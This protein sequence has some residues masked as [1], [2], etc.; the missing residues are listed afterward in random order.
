MNLNKYFAY[1][2][3]KGFSDIEFKTRKNSKLS[4]TVYHS[5]VEQY[6][7]SENETLFIRG[8][9]NGKMVSGTTEN[10]SQIN[11]IID[12]M[13]INAAVIEEEKEQEIFAG[14]ETYKRLK[15]HSD[16]LSK[17]SSSDK[18]N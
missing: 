9:Y 18:L 4:I 5:K 2:K 3:E 17:T 6:Q 12:E 16:K 8:I 13:V 14:S 1:A 11:K 15:T 10:F 7:I